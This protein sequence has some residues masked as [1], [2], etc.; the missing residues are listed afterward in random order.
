MDHWT[1]MGTSDLLA[2][3]DFDLHSQF[4]EPICCPRVP[5][6]KWTLAVVMLCKVCRNYVVNL[7]SRYSFKYI[8][9]KG[10]TCKQ[11][12][13]PSSE[14]PLQ[15][16]IQ[17]QHSKT[18]LDAHIVYNKAYFRAS[19]HFTFLTD[20]HKRLLQ[21]GRE[22]SVCRGNSAYYTMWGRGRLLVLSHVDPI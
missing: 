18:D 3:W 4:C 10:N 16:L 5:P 12:F 11:L 15:V 8:F 2:L 21:C 9:L 14:G 7:S 13:F 1:V 19:L 20:V 22:P 17:G 6:R